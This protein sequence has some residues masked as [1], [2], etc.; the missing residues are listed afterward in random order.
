MGSGFPPMGGE[1][2]HIC[3]QPYG[4]GGEGIK[5]EREEEN[6]R[7]LVYDLYLVGGLVHPEGQGAVR[8][9]ENPGVRSTHYWAPLPSR[10][11]PQRVLGA[12]RTPN[13]YVARLR[14]IPTRLL[15]SSTAAIRHPTSLTVLNRRNAT[16]TRFAYRNREDNEDNRYGVFR[17]LVPEKWNRVF[18]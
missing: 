6:D 1:L 7:L 5:R 17:H 13:L 9:G 16:A 11:L 18:R 2:G 4:N 10:F 15:P 8:P 3:R 12:R 14:T